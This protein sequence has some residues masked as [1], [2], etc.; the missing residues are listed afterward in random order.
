MDKRLTTESAD[1]VALFREWLADAEKQESYNPDAVALA[2]AT[3]EGVPAVRMVLLKGVE[4]NGFIFYTNSE[5]RK[6]H[7]LA[8][9]PHASMCFYW[10]SLRR[11]VRIDG[12]VEKAG[13]EISDAYFAT[14]SRASQ[15]GAWASMQSRPLE[16]RFELEK[17]IAVQTAK[18]AVGAVPRPPFWEGYRLIP[19]R[20]EFWAEQK[21]RLHDRIVYDRAGDGW[22][23]Q[24][25]YP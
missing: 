12:A 24:R 21:F 15:I 4:E 14:R 19:R 9:N 11:Q 6:G 7:E 16:G 13:D 23:V 17:R 18:F 2:T 3:A 8:E 5:S 20:I 22:T 10:K 25:L 1:P